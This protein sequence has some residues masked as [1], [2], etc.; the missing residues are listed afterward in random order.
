MTGTV[1]APQ[2]TALNTHTPTALE[3]LRDTTNDYTRFDVLKI[4]AHIESARST[5]GALLL[6][7]TSE[8]NT[9]TDSMHSVFC[10]PQ[11][12]P[13][14]PLGFERLE[15][16]CRTEFEAVGANNDAQMLREQFEELQA[17]V[18]A[19]A[20]QKGAI[21]AA[22]AFVR[23]PSFGKECRSVEVSYFGFKEPNMGLGDLRPA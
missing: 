20:L 2:G 8:Q 21:I 11:D 13:L 22:V 5:P 4:R 3:T 18:A 19:A 9:A 10:D 15:S 1:T 7:R 12:S 16:F 23:S 14:R 17:R 6:I